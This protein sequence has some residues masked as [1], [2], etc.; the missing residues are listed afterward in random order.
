M[1]QVLHETLKIPL[2]EA[3]TITRKD[4]AVLFRGT[5]QEVEWLREKFIDRGIVKGIQSKKYPD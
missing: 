1:A 5:F 2:V 4:P 3:L